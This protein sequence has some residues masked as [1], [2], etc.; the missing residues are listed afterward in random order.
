[1]DARAQTAAPAETEAPADLA[2]ALIHARRTVLPKRLGEPGPDA[3]QLQR[4]LEAAAA[5][6]DHGERV[7]WRFTL[8]PRGA[9][10]RLAEAFAQALSERDANA[11]AEELSQAREKAFRS[12]VLMLA[13]VDLGSEGDEIPPHERV[14]ATGCALQNLML[15]ATGMGFGSSL[16]SGQAMASRPLRSLFGLGER[17][18]ALCFLNIGTVESHRKPRPRPAVEQY[19]RTLADNESR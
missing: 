14:L 6:P 15:A 11:T 9:R 18:Q 3:A 1:M 17:E 5:A 4:I 16:T 10:W 8:V 19:L 7:P 12:P 13:S 2:T